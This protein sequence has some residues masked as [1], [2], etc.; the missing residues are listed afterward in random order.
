MEDEEGK[1][2]FLKTG[3]S[4]GLASAEGFPAGWSAKK[5]YTKIVDPSGKT[6][7]GLSAARV[8]LYAIVSR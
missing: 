7:Y 4:F 6:H 3:F 8:A 5:D 1:E 2:H